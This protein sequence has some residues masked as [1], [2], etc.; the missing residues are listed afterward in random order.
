MDKYPPI[1]EL[2]PL[3]LRPGR[4]NHL[5]I[6][7]LCCHYW[8]LPLYL[9]KAGR[10]LGYGKRLFLG[11]LLICEWGEFSHI[12]LLG[13]DLK[14]IPPVESIPDGVYALTIYWFSSNGGFRWMT[15]RRRN[16]LHTI[17][18]RG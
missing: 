12:E 6:L 8:R 2:P 14:S 7:E 13:N 16:Q 18:E 5:D 3:A 4:E 17:E 9:E 10:G 1:K 15:I 11:R